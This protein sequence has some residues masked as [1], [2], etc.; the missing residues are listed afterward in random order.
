MC[1]Q[2]PLEGILDERT[3]DARKA[4]TDVFELLLQWKEVPR[5]G[6][7][8]V[9]DECKTGL[10]LA[11]QRQIARHKRKLTALPRHAR[12]TRHVIGIDDSWMGYICRWEANAASEVHGHP[13]F[14]YYQV[15]GGEFAMDLYQATPDKHAQWTR[16][17]QMRAGD[18]IWQQGKIGRCDNLVHKVSN[19]GQDGYT[20]HLF[21]DNPAVGQ[22]F[23]SARDAAIA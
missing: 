13:S 2:S 9:H 12:Y 17:R 19:G 1:A 21:S 15:I 16:T 7:H 10:A 8:D 18:C 22:Q 3:F 23:Q 4:F 6:D 5:Q 11:L 14:A 20:L